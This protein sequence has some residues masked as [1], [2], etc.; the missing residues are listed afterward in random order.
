MLVCQNNCPDKYFILELN[1]R[2]EGTLDEVLIDP[3]Y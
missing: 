1:I 3:V 2:L